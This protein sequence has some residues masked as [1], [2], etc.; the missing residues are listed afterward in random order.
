[1]AV[2]G[3]VVGPA[4][5]AQRLPG[6]VGAW[7]GAIWR[8]LHPEQDPQATVLPVAEITGIGPTIRVSEA[9]R[10]ALEQSFGLE[11]WL[12]EYV[13]SRIPG[14]TAGETEPPTPPARSAHDVSGRHTPLCD[15]H[16]DGQWLSS[17]L[18]AEVATESGRRLGRLTEVRCRT[19][20]AAGRP[21]RLT[22]LRTTRSPFGTELGYDVDDQQGPRPV[23]A[24]F[25]HL[26][27]HDPVVDWAE[28]VAVDLP[29][30][31]IVSD[32]AELLHPDARRGNGTGGRD[33][34]SRPAR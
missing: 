19:G 29:A 26:Q 5:L 24:L 7:T 31:I 18:G 12:R 13:I 3:L 22:Q 4:A 10:V 9:A 11:H 20:G 6:K 1:M 30:T 34:H 27:R 14:A 28:V 33:V 32:A 23:A 25:R 2:R 21:W 15:P 8:R 16:V 17:Y